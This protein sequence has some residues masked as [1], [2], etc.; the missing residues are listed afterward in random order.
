MIEEDEKAVNDFDEV[1]KK[2]PQNAHAYFRRAFSYKRMKVIQL[3]T[4]KQRFEEAAKDFEKAKDLDPL[5]PALVV[6]YKMLDKVDVI[7][8]CE[9]GEEKEFK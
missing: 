5:N 3:V 2:N 4:I 1:I 6:N 9:P 7:V 8:L